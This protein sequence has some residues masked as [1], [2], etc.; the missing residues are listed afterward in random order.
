MKIGLWSALLLSDFFAMQKN[1]QKLSI[2]SAPTIK[3]KAN[4]KYGAVSQPIL[5]HPLANK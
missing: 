2:S 3:P 1:K 4:P 5:K